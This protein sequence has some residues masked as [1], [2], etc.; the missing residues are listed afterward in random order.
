[1]VGAAE[2]LAEP[3]D[4]AGG[5]DELLLTGEKRVRLAGDIDLHQ[6]IGAT[7]FPGDGF[8]RVHGR[9]RQERKIGRGVVED[10][11]TVLGMNALLHDS[12][13]LPRRALQ[14][15]AATSAGISCYKKITNHRARQL[16]RA[17]P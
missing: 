12:A 1:A 9:T 15:F 16:S 17:S 13:P 14:P 8:R 11:R 5:V 3:L 4:A 10:H 6:R 7:I 2:L